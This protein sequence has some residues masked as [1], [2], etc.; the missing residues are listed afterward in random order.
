VGWLLVVPLRVVI[1]VCTL[2]IAAAG[3]RLLHAI[4]D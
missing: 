2:V 1:W 4:F 3:A